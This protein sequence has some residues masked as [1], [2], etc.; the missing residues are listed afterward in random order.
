[1]KESSEAAAWKS[2]SHR[3]SRSRSDAEAALESLAVQYRASTGSVGETAPF[4][5]ERICGAVE[6]AAGEND[7]AAGVYALGVL[8][9]QAGPLL[10]AVGIAAADRIYKYAALMPTALVLECFVFSMLWLD[11]CLC[12]SFGRV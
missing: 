7:I 4:A 5:L 11:Y 6:R 8:R 3:F 12:D 10:A 2:V 1:M 9:E